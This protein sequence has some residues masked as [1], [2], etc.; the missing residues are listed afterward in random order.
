MSESFTPSLREDMERAIRHI[1][2]GIRG[3]RAR[4]KTE[5]EYIEHLEDHVYRL[6]LRGVPE[7]KAVA[8]ALT[9]LG[10][11]ENLCHMLCTVHNR[12]PPEFGV[13]FLWFAL[14]FFGAWYVGIFLWSYYLLDDYP[15][16]HAI[17]LLI[18]FGYA[19]LR[20]LRSFFLRVRAVSRLRRICKKQSY[21]M[22]CAVSPFLSVFFPTRRPEWLVHT[23]DKIYC[24]HFLA[25]HKR[26]ATLRLLDSYVYTITTTH[27]QASRLVERPLFNRFRY[28][29]TGDNT[30]ENVHF[31]SLHF[32]LGAD[33]ATGGVERILLFCPVPSVIQYRNG[34]A[35]EFAGNGDR[36]FGMTLYDGRS[37]ET[38]LKEHGR[39]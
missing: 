26:L 15:I 3:K 11:P 20:Y 7:E 28:I 24:I 10:D 29:R 33:Y 25:V 38:V 37:F 34:T 23:P 18:L 17:P 19:P 9:A 2:R 13:N 1:C 5:Q 32:P 8:E 36:V 30:Y 35:F 6:M 12:L 21:R 27:G 16:L 22:E 39:G 31:H 4:R 14:R